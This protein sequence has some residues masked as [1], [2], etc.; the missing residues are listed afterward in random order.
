[1]LQCPICANNDRFYLYR[2]HLK[3]HKM[4]KVEEDDGTIHYETVGE[5][6]IKFGD[7]TGMRCGSCDYESEDPTE[8]GYQ[9]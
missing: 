7:I 2:W 6:H 8:F 5:Q 4:E 3:K 9:V 1:M